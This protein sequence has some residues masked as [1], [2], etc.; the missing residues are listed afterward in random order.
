MRSAMPSARIARDTAWA[1]AGK[2]P[3]N[4][5]CMKV[6]QSGT[7]H[8]IHRACNS[9]AN[10]FAKPQS[11]REP[12][13]QQSFGLQISDER[14]SA[15]LTEQRSAAHTSLPARQSRDRK[16]FEGIRGF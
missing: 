1:R 6:N 7:D 3:Y 8:G 9:C 12:W 15:L 14:D 10:F 16:T 13:R 5:N 2:K 11:R 4:A